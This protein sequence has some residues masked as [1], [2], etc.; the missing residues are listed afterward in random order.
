MYS[1]TQVLA[2]SYL[3]YG[4]MGRTWLKGSRIEAHCGH[5]S[6][7]MYHPEKRTFWYSSHEAAVLAV[8]N[9][10]VTVLDRSILVFVSCAVPELVLQGLGMNDFDMRISLLWQPVENGI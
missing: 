4:G 1:G 3:L 7:M 9:S 8:Q 10:F 5:M 2:L 6:H